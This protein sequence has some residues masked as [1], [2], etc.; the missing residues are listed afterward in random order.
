MRSGLELPLATTCWAVQDATRLRTPIGIGITLPA[1]H[2]AQSLSSRFYSRPNINVFR[3]VQ[4]YGLSAATTPIVRK[5]LKTPLGGLLC[6]Q[7]N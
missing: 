5:K 3:P 1:P 7:G 4:A 2:Y 6:I